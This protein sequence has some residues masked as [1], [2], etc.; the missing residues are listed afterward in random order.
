MTVL[1]VF[2]VCTLFLLSCTDSMAN[3]KELPFLTDLSKLN[4]T[5]IASEIVDSVGDHNSGTISVSNEEEKKLVLVTMSGHL[6][7]PSKVT[8][9][10]NDFAAVVQTKAFATGPRSVATNIGGFWVIEPD[11]PGVLGVRTAI[12][13]EAG[14]IIVKAAF[15]LH[16]SFREFS[17]SYPALVTGSASLQE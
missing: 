12:L 10:S 3:E 4:L 14:P 11:R 7:K 16:K 6:P 9:R 17:V 1:R 2:L 5:I 13:R 15:I 8:L